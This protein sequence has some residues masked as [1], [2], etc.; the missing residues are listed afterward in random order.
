MLDFVPGISS[1]LSCGGMDLVRGVAVVVEQADCVHCVSC[2]Q[3]VLVSNTR[4][5][6]IEEFLLIY[7]LI[8][9]CTISRALIERL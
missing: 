2:Y 1:H 3:F 9:A 7:V 5:H 6:F 4:M 8:N